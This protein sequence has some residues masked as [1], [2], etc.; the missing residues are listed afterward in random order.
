L[1]ELEE[2]REH[3]DGSIETIKSYL[4]EETDYL[5]NHTCEKIRSKSLYLPGHDFVD[6]TFVDSDRPTQVLRN[7]KSIYN[8]GRLAGTGYVS[9]LPV[10]QGI[11]HSAVASFTPNPM[12]FDPENIIKL[13]LKT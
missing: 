11:E 7:L 2:I 12:Y 1:P 3:M 4:G 6:R 9:I 13:A 10:D 5:L 8:H